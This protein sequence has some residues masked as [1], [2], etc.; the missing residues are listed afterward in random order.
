MSDPEKPIRR[1]V[2]DLLDANC[3][4][5]EEAR[6]HL[7]WG[8]VGRTDVLCRPRAPDFSHLSFAVEVKSCPK[9]GDQQ[10][11]GWIKQAADYV[12]ASPVNGWPAI[13]ATFVWLFDMPLDPRP[14]EQLRMAGMLQLAQYF[15]V[16]SARRAKYGLSLVFGPS[17]DVYKGKWGWA[18]R[19]LELLQARRTL[20]GTRQ[21]LL[22]P[23]P[24]SIADG[25]AEGLPSDLP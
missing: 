12:G 5:L 2:V 1:Q 3:E 18:P 17:A 25:V 22:T 21:K 8:A 10:L 15:R 7:K 24:T 16:G 20:A 19:A 9:V 6:V 14:D 11:A 4:C 23:V 13:A